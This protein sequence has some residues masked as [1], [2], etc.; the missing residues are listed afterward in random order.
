MTPRASRHGLFA[1]AAAGFLLC[2]GLAACG[3]GGGGGGGGVPVLPPG[4]SPPPATT[5]QQP[6][7]PAP[8]LKCA[9]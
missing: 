3:G 1:S 2:L 4:G 9:P 8:V 7:Q 6:G 5:P